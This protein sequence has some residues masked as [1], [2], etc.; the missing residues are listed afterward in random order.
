MFAKTV[1]RTFL[2]GLIILAIPI[3]SGCGGAKTVE[4]TEA[5]TTNTIQVAAGEQFMIVL[6]ANE[7]TGFVWRQAEGT[8]TKV[9][10]KVTDE[11]IEPNTGAVG[12]GGKH[13]WTF[14]GVEA[15]ETTIKLDYLR[16][17]EPDAK[18]DKS[19]TFKVKVPE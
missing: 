1:T 19:L 18:P 14:E 5:D 3:V 6:D 12:A 2:L 15:G 11:Y 16:P 9:V 7:T 17:W 10:K 13:N 8:D 4:Y